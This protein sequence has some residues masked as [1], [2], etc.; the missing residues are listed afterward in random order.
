MKDKLCSCGCGQLVKP[1]NIFINGHN[2]KGLKRDSKTLKKRQETCIERYGVDSVNKLKSIKLKK[3]KTSLKHYGVTSPNTVDS[4]KNK[5]KITC[6]KNYGAEVPL[7]CNEIKEKVKNTNLLKYGVENPMQLDV[8]VEKVRNTN[9]KKY[10]GPTPQHSISVLNKMKQ[11]CMD[12]YGVDNYS[13]TLKFRE[14]SRNAMIDAIENGLKD[15]TKF[16]PRKG[17]NEIKFISELQQYT[18]YFINNDSRLYGLFP[19]GYIEELNMV[20]EFDESYHNRSCYKEH[21]KIKNETYKKEGLL[22]FRVS[23]KVWIN[24]RQIILK[25]FIN[26]LK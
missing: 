13:K 19:D 21:D 23:E 2:T 10:G 12:K 26:L 11:T 18:S 22:L 25:R 9:I 8:I 4:V 14:F 5:K 7:Q 20:I 15:G 3:I 16:S 6:L 1:G 24:N 17:N